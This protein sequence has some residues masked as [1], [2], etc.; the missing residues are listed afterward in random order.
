MIP[1]TDPTG[2][3]ELLIHYRYW[4]L[5]PLSFIEGP[6]VAFIAGALSHLGYFNPYLAFIIFFMKDIILDGIFYVIGRFSGQTSLIRR[7]LAKIGIREEHIHEARILW[8]KHGFRTMLLSKL[9]YGLSPGF[10]IAAGMVG[11]PVRIFFKY[12]VLVSLAQY[13]V[14]FMLGYYFGNAFGNVANVLENIQYAVGAV[15]LVT[16]A[17]YILTRYMGQKLVEEE[18]KVKKEL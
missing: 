17:Y 4:L 2:A 7:L 6:V 10:L 1:P 8:A 18:R 15:L 9:S 11:M 16:I 5:I 14:L 3:M 12:A 13:G